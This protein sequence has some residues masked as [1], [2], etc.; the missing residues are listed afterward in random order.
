M[1]N[2]SLDVA[3]PQQTITIATTGMRY[4]WGIGGKVRG[5]TRGSKKVGW[6][7]GREG[8]EGM[9]VSLFCEINWKRLIAVFS[10]IV[11]VFAV[12]LTAHREVEI[13]SSQGQVAGFS[14][15]STAFSTWCTDLCA[16]PSGWRRP[17]EGGRPGRCLGIVL[18]PF[19]VSR[20]CRRAE[21]GVLCHQ[22]KQETN[23]CA[24]LHIDSVTCW[25]LLSLWVSPTDHDTALHSGTPSSVALC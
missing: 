5:R 22:E 19:P 7:E 20:E 17:S 24:K 23:I 15:K 16:K 1:C 18:V 25:N 11:T 12:G 2:K 10:C 21:R 6:G 4:H 8:W 3:F 9:F 14:K 13:F